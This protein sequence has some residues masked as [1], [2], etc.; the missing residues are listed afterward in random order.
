M[1]KQITI[2]SYQGRLQATVGGSTYEAEGQSPE[3]FSL[4]LSEALG[5]SGAFRVV[6]ADS[7]ARKSAIFLK[8]IL[9]D[10]EHLRREM[11]EEALRQKGELPEKSPW[12]LSKERA[13][14]R[15]ERLEKL[16][17]RKK[18]LRKN[19]GLPVRF[20]DWRTGQMV[21]GRI[22]GV[23]L[24]RKV[25]ALM[26]KIETLPS[27]KVK[28]KRTDADFVFS[29]ED[30]PKWQSYDKERSELI[31]KHKELRKARTRLAHTEKKLDELLRQAEE[32]R[33][34]LNEIIEQVK[35]KI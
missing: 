12:Q 31:Q 19:I 29:P 24:H 34:K 11:I 5:V 13:K 3:E 9:K 17:R 1:G 20:E 14:T 4:N 30:A 22:K 25:S 15:E 18:E 21:P 16:E 6:T 23:V 35:S 28:H 8:K 2:Y 26:Y 7:L 10:A 27:G 32:D 33:Q